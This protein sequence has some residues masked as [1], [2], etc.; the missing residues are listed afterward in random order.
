M[1]WIFDAISNRLKAL[2]AADLAATF[3][4]QLASRQAQRKAEL[5]R[6]ADR[7]AQEGLDTVAGDL[8]DQAEAICIERPLATVLP[9]IDELRN[10]HHEAPAASLIDV[11]AGTNGG[12]PRMARRP[13]SS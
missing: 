1:L 2:F 4:S 3:E 6:Q 11:P 8:R 12:P 7:F 9:S 5:L 13:N 10:D